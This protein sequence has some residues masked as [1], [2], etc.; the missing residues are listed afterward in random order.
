MQPLVSIIMPLYNGEKFIRGTLESVLAQTYENWELIIIDDY[1][2]DNSYYIIKDYKD[3]RIHYYK[4]I[5]NIGVAYSRNKGMELARGEYI[6]FLD[7]DDIWNKDK[8]EKQVKYIIENKIEIVHSNYYFCDEK[9]LIIKSIKNDIEID[10][11][12]LLK[13]NQIKT[14]FLLVKRE[15]INN[16][17]FKNIKHEDYLFFLDFLAENKICYCIQEE[18]GK[19]RI[20][21]NSLSSNKIKSAKWTWDIYKKYKRFSYIKSIYYFINYIIN[22]YKKYR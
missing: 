20:S 14:S 22:G 1:S 13:G 2:I 7:S 11:N 4:N 21:S 9:D 3:E 16:K 15:I 12:K 5:K 18:L 17:K 10:Y 8:I 6:A 19:Y